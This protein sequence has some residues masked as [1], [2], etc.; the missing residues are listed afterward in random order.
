MQETAFWVFEKYEREIHK[1]QK[2]LYKRGR[3]C[4]LR[5]NFG[6][7]LDLH[8]ILE[9]NWK[10]TKEREAAITVASLLG[11]ALVREGMVLNCINKKRDTPGEKCHRFLIK[12][13]IRN[14][15]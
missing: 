2:I 7:T 8:N 11:S 6:Y 4:A 14:L 15:E 3:F 12:K 9:K 1:E 13:K 5:I 10:R